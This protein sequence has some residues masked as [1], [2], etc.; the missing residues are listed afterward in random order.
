MIPR[1]DAIGLLL[2]IEA[3]AEARLEAEA[4]ERLERQRLAAG[5]DLM[6]TLD[7]PDTL[8]DPASFAY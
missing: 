6:D 2:Y 4:N 8:P 7:T 3:L 5:L 1:R